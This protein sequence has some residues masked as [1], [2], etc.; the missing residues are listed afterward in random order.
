MTDLMAF[1]PV[2]LQDRMRHYHDDFWVSRTFDPSFIGQVM[3]AGFL[4]IA[5][6]QGRHCYLLP[7]LHAQR[8]VIS[9]LAS[10]HVP[11]QVRK[12]SKGFHLTFNTAFDSVVAGCH[13]Q[14]GQ[15]W[16]YPPV[17]TAFRAML[18]GVPVADQGRQVQLISVEL[19]NDV[20][21]LVA[22]ELGYTNGAMYTSLTG[23]TGSNGAGTMQLY[24]LGAYLH[25]C[26]FQLWDLG[27][28]MPYKLALGARD[29]PRT[30]FVQIMRQLRPIDVTL[31]PL[32]MA[33]LSA[34]ELFQVHAAASVN[35]RT[36][37]AS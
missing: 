18:N 14:H 32:A 19:W 36:S 9:S 34:K 24:A 3:Y 37:H 17:V 15:A 31:I 16:L 7:K 8:C 35:G 21:D 12:K 6:Q 26:G 20:N 28:S 25:Q 30:E 23:F 33:P 10:L 1:V 22:G 5:T 13:A 11:K 4:P 2:D 29:I 27:M